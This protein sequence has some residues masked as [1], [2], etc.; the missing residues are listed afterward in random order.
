MPMEKA[1]AA[2]VHLLPAT[3]TAFALSPIVC[4]THPTFV[5]TGLSRS[6]TTRLAPQYS[7][8]KEAPS[9]GQMYTCEA[10]LRHLGLD[11]SAQTYMLEL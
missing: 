4:S 8:L 7:G 11:A 10:E 9:S 1:K 2:L 6:S 3:L 5:A